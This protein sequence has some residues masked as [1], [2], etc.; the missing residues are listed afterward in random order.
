M[1]GEIGEVQQHH[2]RIEPRFFGM[3]A[4]SAPKPMLPAPT[5]VPSRAASNPMESVSKS[6]ET[7]PE[8]THSKM[9]TRSASLDDARRDVIRTLIAFRERSVKALA[10]GATNIR[11]SA[12]KTKDETSGVL[13]YTCARG[14]AFPPRRKMS[15]M[16]SDRI[17]RGASRVS[18]ISS[19]R[20]GVHESSASISK[21]DVSSA[22]RKTLTAATNIRGR[23][24]FVHVPFARGAVDVSSS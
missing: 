22:A 2:V 18:V 6:V 23:K 9:P 10:R 11:L 16:S 24:T 12:M 15:A 8:M 7:A 5:T 14:D 21:D 17:D 4:R 3:A 1:E 13:Q 20:L 19:T